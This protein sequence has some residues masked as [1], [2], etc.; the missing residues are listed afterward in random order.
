MTSASDNANQTSRYTYDADGKRNDG[1]LL[2]VASASVSWSAIM[3]RKQDQSGEN[4]AAILVRKLQ[5]DREGE[6][7]L[8]KKGLRSMAR[9]SAQSREQVIR[10]L[11]KLVGG[12]E[13]VLRASSTVHYDAWSF[14]AELLGQVKAVEALDVLIAC[15]NCNDG[16]HGLSAYRFPAFRALIMIGPEAVPKLVKALSDSA[17]STRGRAASALGEIG[18]ADAK[19][20]LEQALISERDED[21]VRSIKI[22]L[23]KQ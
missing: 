22:A 15:I 16:M 19:K 6:R 7:T 11:V 3:P 10:E 2:L 9:T 12:S 21:V 18:G 4:K 14:A 13:A 8:A 23:R 5:S 20:A 1:K 17:A